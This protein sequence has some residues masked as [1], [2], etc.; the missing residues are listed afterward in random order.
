MTHNLVDIQTTHNSVNFDPWD[1]LLYNE[2][3]NNGEK[4]W[5]QN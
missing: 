4:W 5:T 1:E 2:K 3:E